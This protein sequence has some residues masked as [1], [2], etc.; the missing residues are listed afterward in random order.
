M[1]FVWI[2]HDMDMLPFFRKGDSERS[3]FLR[4]GLGFG[5]TEPANRI[6]H[7]DGTE[8]SVVI[9]DVVSGDDL[10]FT[11]DVG[12]EGGTTHTVHL[13]IRKSGMAILD[14][15]DDATAWSADSRLFRSIEERI[16]RPFSP[17]DMGSEAQS[18]WPTAFVSQASDETAACEDMADS[19]ILASSDAV[20][21]IRRLIEAR[22]RR[23]YSELARITIDQANGDAR[24]ADRVL[25]DDLRMKNGYVNFSNR[26][27]S[28]IEDRCNSLDRYLQVCSVFMDLF[29]ICPER[30]VAIGNLREHLGS[31]H[32]CAS[33]RHAIDMEVFGLDATMA[34]AESEGVSREMARSMG[35]ISWAAAVL[36][37]ASTALAIAEGFSGADSWAFAAMAGVAAACAISY[38][39]AHLIGMRRASASRSRSNARSRT[40]LLYPSAAIT[41][42]IW[43]T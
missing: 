4:E 40:Y 20:Q 11:V 18:R 31:L 35:R 28:I 12:I 24:D 39:A 26:V 19:M 16:L 42:S 38:P 25:F 6:V 27:D 14:E 22:S 41:L 8:T 37:G 29:R 2:P 32:G 3:S 1:V 17:L 34:T 36:T 15:S 33:R 10:V 23:S 13:T 5:E 7:E 30:A 43:Q 9:R 21:S